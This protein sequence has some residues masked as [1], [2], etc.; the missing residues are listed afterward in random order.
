M[1]A[2]PY[3]L[4]KVRFSVLFFRYAIVIWILQSYS[5]SGGMRIM[6]VERKQSGRRPPHYVKLNEEVIRMSKKKR[7]P[8][9]KKEEKKE[10]Y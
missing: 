7:A 3:S 6:F 8:K 5:L 2:L 9:K 1:F 10:E 4:D